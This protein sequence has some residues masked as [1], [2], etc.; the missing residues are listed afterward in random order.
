[1]IFLFAFGSGTYAKSFSDTEN[2]WAK[3]SVDFVT[4]NGYFVGTSAS[5]FSPKS[6]ITRGQFVTVLARFEKVDTSYYNYS[7]F[8]DVK[9]GCY[10]TA[11]ITWAYQ[12]GIVYG[13]DSSHFSPDS[14]ITREQICFIINNYLSLGTTAVMGS[15]DHGR[16]GIYADDNEIFDNFKESVYQ[17]QSLGYMVG[18]NGYFRPKSNMTRAE[19]AVIISRLCGMFYEV[20]V[21][22]VTPPNPDVGTMNYLGYYRLTCYCAGCNSPRGSR[23]TS[24]GAFA[25]PGDYGT[26]A[27]SPALY[28][29]YGAGTVL[30]I[31][32]VGFRKIQDKHGNTEKVIDVYVSNDTTC[33]CW[34]HPFSGKSAKVYIV[35]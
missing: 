12:N 28:E 27:V 1:M 5:T 31:D 6:N 17:M 16:D 34:S 7:A 24:S 29:M 32:G 11:A 15:D 10:Y 20:F 30:Y 25:T 23:D 21:P 13:T 18:N 26:I 9:P 22:P 35:R 8:E 33:K 2:H 3:Y 19:G 14:P 4:D